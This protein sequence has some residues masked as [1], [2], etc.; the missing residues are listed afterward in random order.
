METGH[1]PQDP[2]TGSLKDDPRLR[3]LVT[4]LRE[5]SEEQHGKLADW[6]TDEV[7]ET[8]P[9]EEGSDHDG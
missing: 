4:E 2:Q 8:E 3:A 9:V 7:T 5:Q 1:D 6:V